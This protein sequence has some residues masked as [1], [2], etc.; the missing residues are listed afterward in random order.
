MVPRAR[1]TLRS[2]Q[3]QSIG[4]QRDSTPSGHHSGAARSPRHR[5]HPTMHCSFFRCSH[6]CTAFSPR[7]VMY[8]F[9][10]RKFRLQPREGAQLHPAR[11]RRGTFLPKEPLVMQAADVA[12]WGL[13]LMH[14]G[15]LLSSQ[16]EASVAIA[17]PK[18]WPTTTT[19]Q[20]Q[21]PPLTCLVPTSLETAMRFSPCFHTVRTA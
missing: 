12:D 18:L 15:I 13:T 9:L 5:G 14:L 2:R 17:A 21:Q 4:D 1:F 19:L 11:K 7:I 6:A 16:T 10:L 3:D 20:P 8:P